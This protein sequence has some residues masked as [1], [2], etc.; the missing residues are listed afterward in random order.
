MIRLSFPLFVC[1]LLL[2]ACGSGDSGRQPNAESGVWL[3]TVAG[4]QLGML[5]PEARELAAARGDALRCQAATTRFPRGSVEDTVWQKMQDVDYCRPP[6]EG[7]ELAFKQGTLFAV[8][9]EYSEDW[10]RIPLDTL[11]RRLSERAGAPARREVRP[12]GDGRRE[13]LVSWSDDNPAVMSLRCFEGRS[14]DEC[15]RDHYLSR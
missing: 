6:D 15:R 5:L 3:D 7:M 10:A 1:A 11:I 9:V 12:Y 14:S 2:S 8:T 13:V 4:F